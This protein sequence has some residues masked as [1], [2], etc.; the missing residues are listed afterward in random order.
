MIAGP[1]FHGALLII[2]EEKRNCT[3]LFRKYSP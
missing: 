1:E 3:I 2:M